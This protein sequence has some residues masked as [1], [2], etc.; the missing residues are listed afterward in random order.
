MPPARPGSATGPLFPAMDSVNMGEFPATEVGRPRSIAGRDAAGPAGMVFNIQRYSIRDGP[1]IRT[2]V[3]LKGCPLRC[4]WCHN[5]ESYRQEPEHSFLASRCIG[6]GRCLEACLTGALSASEAGVALD[7]A[8]CQL[9][10]SCVQACPTGAREIIGRLMTVDAVMKAVERDLPF[11]EQSGGG[12]TFSGGEPLLQ[13][14]FLEGLLAQCKAKEIHTALDTTCYAPWEV[15]ESIASNVDL[16]LCDL[17]HMEAEAHRR[18]TGVSNE[19]I[20]CNV[21]R[22]AELGARLIIRLPVIPGV[23]DDMANVAATGEFAASLPG[24]SQIDLLPHNEAGPGK[25]ARLAA[26]HRMLAAARPSG[27]Q[28]KAM[29]EAL[30]HYGL[31]VRIG[32]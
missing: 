31:A 19:L 18:F 10:G 2:T 23:N 17:K 4:V 29:A 21:R 1:G 20:L 27:E 32:G 15:V 26:G 30:R 24:V 14:A 22:L 11:Y 5:P 12:V 8:K 6:C 9:C 25:S 16:H 3:F 28:M 13:S 7:T